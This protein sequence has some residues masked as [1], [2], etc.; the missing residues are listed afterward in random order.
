MPVPVVILGAG[1][2]AREVLDVFDAANQ[3]QPRWEVLGFL[4]EVPEDWGRLVHDLPCLGGLEWLDGRTGSAD[5][6][7]ICG[8]GSTV[9]ELP[10][11]VP[12][13]WRPPPCGTTKTSMSRK[14]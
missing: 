2:H 14:A 8:I 11:A 9:V 13:R 3:V 5:L 10:V 4:S 6:R 12:R 7:V 1:G